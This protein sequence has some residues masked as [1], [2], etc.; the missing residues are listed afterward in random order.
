MPTALSYKTFWELKV[1]FLNLTVQTSNSPLSLKSH[2]FYILHMFGG[3]V[4]LNG[5]GEKRIND[6]VVSQYLPRLG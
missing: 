6:S 3:S 4:L 5:G 1:S 2:E